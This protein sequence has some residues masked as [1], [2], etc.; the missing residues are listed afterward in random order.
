MSGIKKLGVSTFRW[1]NK[2]A[3]V[4]TLSPFE[5]KEKYENMPE[6]NFTHAA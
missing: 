6:E 4:K 5:V 2:I 1:E 3:T